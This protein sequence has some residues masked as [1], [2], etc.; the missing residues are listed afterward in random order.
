MPAARHNIPGWVYYL[1]LGISKYQIEDKRFLFH[2]EIMQS[3]DIHLGI[4][5]VLAAFPN[6]RAHIQDWE[7][8]QVHISAHIKVLEHIQA[9]VCEFVCPGSYMP[10]LGGSISQFNPLDRYFNVLFYLRP[11]KKM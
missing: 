5:A 10:S 9:L 11:D 3:E 7:Y 2:G 8:I 4:L 1:Q 6:T